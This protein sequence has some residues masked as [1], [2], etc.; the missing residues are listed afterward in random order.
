MT[1]K[2]LC[3]VN[4]FDMKKSKWT[5]SQIDLLSQKASRGN[6]RTRAFAEVA[7]ATGRRANSVRNF[8]Y[9]NLAREKAKFVAF[10]AGEVKGILREIVLGTSRGESVRSICMRL[11]GGDR[12]KMLR[13]QNKYRA[14]VKSDPAAIE[15]IKD[16][17]EEQRYLVKSPLAGAGSLRGT[18]KLPFKIKGWTPQADGVSD[19]I[20]T[21]PPR[22]DNTVSDSD[23]NN[24]FLGLMRLVKKQ[25]EDG[26]RGQIEMLK[27]EI[28]RLK[29]VV[30]GRDVK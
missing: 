12:T 2:S 18:T 6:V 25:A 14:I 24:L 11:G 30:G 5:Q 7:R 20:I 13:I 21:L 23:I 28:E 4:N 1:C 3:F 16:E 27:T 15:A 22:T 8:Y 26:A 19:N 29:A 10:T 9:K 17:L